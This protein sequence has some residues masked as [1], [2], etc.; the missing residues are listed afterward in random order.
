VKP[1]GEH[2]DRDAIKIMASNVLAPNRRAKEFLS[3]VKDHDPDVLVTLE[4][5]QWWQDHLNDLEKDYPYQ[6]KCPLE[7]CY[8]MHLFSKLELS[9][10]KVEFLVDSDKPSIHTV[11][12]LRSGEKIRAHFLHP[13]PPGPEGLEKSSQ[14][15]AEL[16]VVA[17]S[18]AD[19]RAPVIVAGDLNDVAWSTTTRLF[20]KI[21]GLLDPRVGRGMFNTFHAGHWYMRWPLDHLF[22][23]RHFT[24][25]GIRRLR[26]IGSDHFALYTE[27]VHTP[28]QFS[29]DNH[30]EADAEDRELAERKM[31]QKNVDESDVPRLSLD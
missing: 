6:V 8:G 28:G 24:L 29:P 18:V 14:R 7:N 4:T 11:V 17:K 9:E 10:S 31:A 27:L 25:S 12:A 19:S 22:H 3:L 30:L 15:D 23:S 2:D 13:A 26:V 5:D 16:I 1:A 20:R 21:S